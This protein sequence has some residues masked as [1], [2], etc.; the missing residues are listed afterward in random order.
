VLG[1]DPVRSAGCPEGR[2]VVARVVMNRGTRATV[3]RPNISAPP[4]TGSRRVE[5]LLAAVLVGAL[6]DCGVRTDLTSPP[7]VVRSDVA[8]PDVVVSDAAD[9]T[10]DVDSG[11]CPGLVVEV[12]PTRVLGGDGR[13]Y[14]F[15]SIVPRGDGFDLVAFHNEP[16]VRMF[17][18]VA[19]RLRPR[20]SPFAIEM[21]AMAV[22]DADGETVPRAGAIGDALVSCYGVTVNGRRAIRLQAHRDAYVPLAHHEIEQPAGPE[23]LAFAAARDRGIAIWHEHYEMDTGRVVVGLLTRNGEL[24]GPVSTTSVGDWGYLQAGVF[25]TGLAWISPTDRTHAQLTLISDLGS[26]TAVTVSAATQIS[27]P[28][29][30][31]AWPFDPRAAAVVTEELTPGPTMVTSQI[32]VRVIDAAAGAVALERA[33]PRRYDRGAIV[34]VAPFAS[35]LVVVGAEYDE[36]GSAMGSIHVALVAADGTP[37]GA[38]TDLRFARGTTNDTND[39][40]MAAQGGHVILAWT[41]RTTPAAR[42]AEIWAT[43]LGCR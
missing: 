6:F 16:N 35:G 3:T 15:P 42:S 41:S 40:S 21:G 4:N 33:L 17:E 1:E 8:L 38:D 28:A 7:D 37:R 13:T 9:V 19:R 29:L 24:A 36:F 10:R 27:P 26:A 20:V 22:L 14:V 18:P 2:S 31:T 5:S 30:I 23:C 25:G 34:S 12:P 11:Q 39:F 32:H 43:M